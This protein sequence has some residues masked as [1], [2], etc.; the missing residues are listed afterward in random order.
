MARRKKA[1]LASLGELLAGFFGDWLIKQGG[2]S[3]DTVNSYRDAWRLFLLFLMERKGVCVSAVTLEMLTAESVL[4]F[5]EYVVEVRGCGVNT[6]NQR[7]AAIKSFSKYAILKEP[8]TMAQF[9]R[10][11]MI[12]RMRKVERALGYLT[13]DEMMAMLD[14]PDRSTPR[15]RRDYALLLLMY[16]TGA[17]VSEVTRFCMIDLKRSTVMIHGKGS[18]DRVVPIWD[19]TA[20]VI[21]EFARE[22]K[23]DDCEPLFA[24]NR[25]ESLTRHGVSCIVRKYAQIAK[26]SCP[27]ID[28]QKVTPHTIRHTTAMHLLQSGV[29]VNLIRM[30]LGHV[31]LSTTNVYIEADVEMKRRALQKGGIIKGDGYSWTPDEATSQFLTTLGLL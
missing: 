22:R 23:V 13:K 20:E 21:E 1:E 19:E 17:R 3:Q 11:L 4:D 30:W 18:K 10:I 24:G 8:A 27:T 14:A 5:L 12:P 26:E 2:K 28:P 31:H 25:D 29:D 9:Q 6:R 7:L 16:N 15:G